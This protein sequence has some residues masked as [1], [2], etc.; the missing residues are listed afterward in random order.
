VVCARIPLLLI[1]LLGR[2]AHQRLEHVGG[3]RAKSRQRLALVAVP[4]SGAGASGRADEAEVTPTPRVGQKRA[5]HQPWKEDAPQGNVADGELG[6]ESRRHCHPEKQH[7]EHDWGQ[8]VHDHDLAEAPRRRAPVLV[9]EPQEARDEARGEREVQ[10]Q[11]GRGV[12]A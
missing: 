8:H 9:R 4:L 12:D 5:V 6:E 1:P 3:G 11:A 10:C 2:L 7:G